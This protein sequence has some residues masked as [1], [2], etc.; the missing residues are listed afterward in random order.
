MITGSVTFIV[1][2]G[3]NFRAKVLCPSPIFFTIRLG[4][5]A[6]Q[7]KERERGLLEGLRE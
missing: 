4:R 2:G 7:A 1:E 5:L 3:S 6:E